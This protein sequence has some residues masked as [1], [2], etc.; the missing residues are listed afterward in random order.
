MQIDLE[1][2]IG[3]D[4]MINEYGN[5]VAASDGDAEIVSGFDCLFQ[6]V[7]NEAITQPGDLFYYDEYGW[8]LLD[9]MHAQGD[10]ITQLEFTQ[11]I[12]NKLSSKEFVDPDSIEVSIRAWVT[13]KITAKVIFQAL[14]LTV[15]L[16]VGVTDR[17]SVEVVNV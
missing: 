4:I 9:F 17:V 5:F 8:G 12:K 2:L 10:E 16:D 14:G 13:E 11:R 1:E 7:K 6:E 3:S 15:E